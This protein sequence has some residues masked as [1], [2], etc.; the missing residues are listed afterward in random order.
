LRRFSVA[1]E[2]SPRPACGTEKCYTVFRYARKGPAAACGHATGFWGPPVAKG[3]LRTVDGRTPRP[4]RRPKQVPPSV[5]ETALNRVLSYSTAAPAMLQRA[6]VDAALRFSPPRVTSRSS[7]SFRRALAYGASCKTSGI[8]RAGGVAGA[9]R[10][11]LML[12]FVALQRQI[13]GGRRTS[14]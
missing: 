8:E 9:S 12:H 2:T 6:L 3:A 10:E 13:G 4:R 5:P 11:A 14:P 7:L 1:A